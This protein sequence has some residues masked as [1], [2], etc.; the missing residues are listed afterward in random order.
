MNAS[1]RSLA[2]SGNLHNITGYEITMFFHK[3]FLNFLKKNLE[4]PTSAKNGNKAI[5]DSLQLKAVDT[6]DSKPFAT[7]VSGYFGCLYPF[8]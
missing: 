4:A 7:L 1:T 3:N 6:F 5:V 8:R 2:R